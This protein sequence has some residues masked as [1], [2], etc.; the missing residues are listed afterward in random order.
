M[1]CVVFSNIW[2]SS[3]KAY[4]CFNQYLVHNI[5]D[6]CVWFLTGIRTSLIGC[7]LRGSSPVY[8]TWP[9]AIISRVCGYRAQFTLPP[10]QIGLVVYLMCRLHNRRLV[11]CTNISIASSGCPL[12]SNKKRFAFS[13]VRKSK[14]VIPMLGGNTVQHSKAAIGNIFMFMHVLSYAEWKRSRVA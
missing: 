8:T 6:Y 10:V 7:S 4:G 9:L 13:F 11:C 2:Y 12:L 5:R 14:S 3:C 1:L